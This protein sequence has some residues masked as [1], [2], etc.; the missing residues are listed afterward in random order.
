[1]NK[2]DSSSP[3]NNESAA[4][5]RIAFFERILTRGEK[6]ELQFEEALSGLQK[7]LPEYR[8]LFHYYFDGKWMEDFDL[9]QSGGLPD[10]LARGVL[11]EDAVYDLFFSLQQL[12]EQLKALSE[13]IQ[14][15]AGSQ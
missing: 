9:D 11:S 7:M 13:E 12:C 2:Q 8:Q 3:S 1:M 6:T 14:K 15:M 10:D 5:A 4:A